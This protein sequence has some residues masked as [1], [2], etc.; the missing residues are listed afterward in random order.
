MEIPVELHSMVKE[1]K[2]LVEPKNNNSYFNIETKKPP[3]KMKFT[4]KY[5]HM[6][7]A[8]MEIAT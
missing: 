7:I 2:L 5:I 4:C 3:T 8:T 1:N 6:E